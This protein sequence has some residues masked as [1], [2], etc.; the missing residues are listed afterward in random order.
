MQQYSENQLNSNPICANGDN[1]LI[2]PLKV[3][4]LLM[5]KD[6]QENEPEHAD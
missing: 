1:L 6:P 3:G 2:K 5:I 4:P